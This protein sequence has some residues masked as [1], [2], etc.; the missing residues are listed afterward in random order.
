MKEE[1]AKEFNHGAEKPKASGRLRRFVEDGVTKQIAAFLE[2]GN[3]PSMVIIDVANAKQMFFPIV[4]ILGFLFEWMALR[5]MVLHFEA[6]TT[7]SPEESSH[8]GDAG[9]DGKFCGLA[10]QDMQLR[11]CHARAMHDKILCI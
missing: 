4:Q 2:I 9:V 11:V 7:R 5:P 10:L 8:G 6:I 3:A 1:P